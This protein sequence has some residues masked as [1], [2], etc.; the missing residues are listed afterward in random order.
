MIT[1][2]SEN[3]I[4]KM[5]R[6]GRIVAEVLEMMRERVAPGVTTAELNELA[7]TVIRKHNAI[8][9]FKGYPPGS[10]HP[11]PASICASVNAELVHGIPGP[12]VLQEGDIISVDVGAI[13]DGYHGDAAITLPVG[14]VGPEVQRL[15]EVTEG[16]LYA[17]IAAAREGNRSGDISAAIQSYVESRGYNVVREYTGHG[18]GRRMHEDPQVPNHG[19]A[20][21]GVL[22]RKGM[23]IALEPMVLTGDH[24]VRV[25][26]DHWT[27]V[28][29]DGELT[30]H[31]EHTFA[32]TNGDAE[33]LTRLD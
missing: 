8:P 7:E 33:I 24:R 28:S 25:L 1:L 20:G 23:T 18:I 11:F 26:D 19:Q 12:Y 21:S 15:L 5:R 14:Q 27:V 6:A 17:G 31:F 10:R 30:A 4:A 2:K 32:I 3:E 29:C 22:L 13:L 9:S 16:A